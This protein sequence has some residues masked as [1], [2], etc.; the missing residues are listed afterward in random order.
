[1]SFADIPERDDNGEDSGFRQVYFTKI[2]P[3]VTTRLR[4]LDRKAHHVVKHW[5]PNQ[6][7]SVL[8]L[9]DDCPICQNNDRLIRENPD[10]SPYDIDGFISRQNRYMTNVYNRTL[11]K[12]TEDGEIVYPRDGNFPTNAP[13][14]GVLITDI[15]PAPLNRVE[16]LERGPELFKQ[17]NNISNA[18]SDEAGNPIGIWNYDIVISASGRGL[19]MVTN[20]IPYQNHNE[21][22]EI[23]EEQLYNLEDVPLVL[24][25]EEIERVLR[26]VSLRD[27]FSARREGETADSGLDDEAVEVEEDVAESIEE[28]FAN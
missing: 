19:N 5:I 12:K 26:G 18:I 25:P 21:D 3:G 27:I 10:T 1:M 16:V 11:V 24:E 13:E 22:L 14:S 8:C 4:I 23:P 6:R 20:V 17:F 9:G 15:E 28:L 2:I 7:I